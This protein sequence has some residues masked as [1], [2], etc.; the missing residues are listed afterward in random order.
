MT[1]SVS[2]RQTGDG[3]RSSQAPDPCCLV[4]LGASGDLTRRKLVPAVFNLLLDGLLPAEFAVVGTARRDLT[5]EAF[6]KDLR[7]G[8]VD[9]SRQALDPE[10]WEKVAARTS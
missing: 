6:A 1:E 4:I 9:H 3:L 10:A 8:V 7:K 2:K 5:A